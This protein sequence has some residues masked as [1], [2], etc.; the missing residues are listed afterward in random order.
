MLKEAPQKYFKT[1]KKNKDGAPQNLVIII[2]DLSP[3]MLGNM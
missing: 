1:N 3:L 2:I